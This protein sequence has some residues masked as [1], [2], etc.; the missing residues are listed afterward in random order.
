MAL[1]L[2]PE[3][4]FSGYGFKF[5]NTILATILVDA[6]LLSLVFFV[7]KNLKPIPG[8]LQSIM[9]GAI[10]Y[11]YDTTEQIA[12]KFTSSIFPWFAS[13]FIFIFASNIIG[14]LPGFGYIG[15]FRIEHGEHIFVPLLRAGTSDFNLTFALA[16]ISLVA[17]HYLAIK[18]NGLAE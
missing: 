9:E 12:G 8:K 6:I 7:N 10:S 16:V 2:A 17:T 13:F 4:I 11:F 14:L 1:S 5:T 3:V 18:Y 15:F